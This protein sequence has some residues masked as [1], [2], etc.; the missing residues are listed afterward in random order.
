MSDHDKQDMVTLMAQKR[1]AES[2]VTLRVVKGGGSCRRPTAEV[3]ACFWAMLFCL[4]AGSFA[5]CG[6]EVVSLM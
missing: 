5:S 1:C 2:I 6:V 4:K 3:T